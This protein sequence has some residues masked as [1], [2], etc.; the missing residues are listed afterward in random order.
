MAE[1][2]RSSGALRYCIRVTWAEK[3]A[4]PCPDCSPQVGR[5]LLGV[6]VLQNELSDC[7]LPQGPGRPRGPHPAFLLHQLTVHQGHQL[8]LHGPTQHALG[9]AA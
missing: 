3:L 9:C 2:D 5:E 4:A 8:P 7:A 6:L 1:K